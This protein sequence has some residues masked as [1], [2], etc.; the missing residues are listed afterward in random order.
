MTFIYSYLNVSEGS[1]GEDELVESTE[2]GS[3]EGVGLG[4]VDLSGVVKVEFGPGSWEELSHVGLHLGLGHL[5]GDEEDL[6]ASF[7]AAVLLEDLGSSGL[8]GGVGDWDGVVVE[9]VVHNIV[10]ISTEESGGWG[11][12]GSWWW[13]LVNEPVTGLIDLGGDL[14]GFDGCKESSQNTDVGEFHFD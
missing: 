7:L 8:T 1:W 5:L 3:H 11:S 4:D 9:D 13:G 12:A 6:S 14:N 10:L 2:E